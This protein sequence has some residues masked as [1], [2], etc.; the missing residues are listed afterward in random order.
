MLWKETQP[1]QYLDFRLS[2]PSLDFWPP[3]LED[4]KFVLCY[5]T[6]L[7]FMIIE[8][9]ESKYR[10]QTQIA[11]SLQSDEEGKSNAHGSFEPT[12]W[13]WEVFS[14]SREAESHV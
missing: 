10:H 9:T 4:H 13:G 2:R 5:D 1:C 11:S 14:S 8:A 12:F 7:W 3:K 6:A